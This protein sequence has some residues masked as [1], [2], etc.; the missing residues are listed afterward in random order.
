MEGLRMSQEKE[1]RDPVHNYI[2]IPEKICTTFIDT[3]IFQRLREIEQTGIRVLFPAARHCRFSHSLGV[4]HLGK[5]AFACFKKNVEACFDGLGPTEWEQYRKTFQI[6]C[7]L[8]DCA[9]AP[10]SHTFEFYYDKKPKGGPSLDQ[11][12]LGAVSNNEAF[13]EDY[14]KIISG[15]KGPAPHEKASAYFVLTH[16][17]EKIIL[18]DGDPVLAARMILGCRHRIIENSLE[19][20]ENCLI[21]L[22][23]GKA[24][25][26]DKLDY[27]LRDTWVS[28]IDNISIDVHR[29]LAA[30]TYNPENHKLAYKKSALSVLESV[31]DARN[32]LHRWIYGHH[33]VAYRQHLLKTSV[34]KL[35]ELIKPKNHDS[36]LSSIFSLDTFTSDVTLPKGIKVYL[37]ADFDI[38]SMLK[39]H[40]KEI[41]EVEELFSRNY[42]R[43]PLWKTWAEF[44]R[45]FRATDNEGLAVLDENASNTD[46]D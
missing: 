36:V 26:V 45:H 11:K 30:L 31:V 2:S 15:E 40:R 19:G 28:G 1:F 39:K 38:L 14:K 8:H 44:S 42:Q 32:Y 13:E 37:P 22:L 7:L 23:N 5:K 20:L 25:D 9:H 35:A 16:F 41:P 3:E 4:Y 43:K 46:C 6:A 27:I 10:F 29:L 24:I 21:S 33:K 34:K 12:L 17:R 18:H